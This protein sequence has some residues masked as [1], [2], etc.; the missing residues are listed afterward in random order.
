M[1]LTP[2]AIINALQANVVEAIGNK[3][4]DGDNVFDTPH[5]F[6]MTSKFVPFLNEHQHFGCPDEVECAVLVALAVVAETWPPPI[7]VIDEILEL[8]EGIPKVRERVRRAPEIVVAYALGWPR[9]DLNNLGPRWAPA[10]RH[11]QWL[12]RSQMILATGSCL[13]WLVDN[14]GRLFDPD[15]TN[16]TPRI[17]DSFTA[18]HFELRCHCFLRGLAPANAF[19]AIANLRGNAAAR[20][21]TCFHRHH[22]S[23]WDPLEMPL[24]NFAARAVQGINGTFKSRWGEFASGMLYDVLWHSEKR[25]VIVNVANRECQRCSKKTIYLSCEFCGLPL[26]ADPQSRN[27]TTKRRL[28]L[29]QGDVEPK[30]S[31]TCHGLVDVAEA[32]KEQCRNIYPALRCDRSVCGKTAHDVCPVCGAPHPMGRK[33]R[34]RQVYF[35]EH[36]PVDVPIDDRLQ[37]RLAVPDT[38]NSFQH[39]LTNAATRALDDFGQ[40]QWVEELLSLIEEEKGFLR[41]IALVQS[42]G[43]VD[44]QKLWEALRDAPDLPSSP[45]RLKQAFEETIKP[46]L[47]EIFRFTWGLEDLDWSLI[48]KYRPAPTRTQ[49]REGEL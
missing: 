44:W 40:E 26:P 28:I 46:N 36:P 39:L 31:W 1:P 17:F 18:A 9:P 48:N 45:E 30:V 33:R 32:Q 21:Q 34:T 29:E 37:Q 41:W 10:L 14:V 13:E 22:L 27:V 25:V 4:W 47:I 23:V 35:L 19:A 38:A 20:A 43:D 11:A 42:D 7:D 12:L 6:V 15:P 5:S 49:R 2:P 3:E 8:T 16:W 24:W